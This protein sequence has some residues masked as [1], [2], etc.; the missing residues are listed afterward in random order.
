[1]QGEDKFVKDIIKTHKEFKILEKTPVF[2]SLPRQQKIDIKFGKLM[3]VY[4]KHKGLTQKQLAPKIGI[5][6]STVKLIEKGESTVQGKDKL[7]DLISREIGWSRLGIDKLIG[8]NSKP[9][10]ASQLGLEEA[11]EDFANA[12]LD[13][14]SYLEFFLAVFRIAQSFNVPFK[15]KTDRDIDKTLD[16]VLVMSAFD[17]LRKV[18][19]ATFFLDL[20]YQSNNKKSQKRN[21]ARQ[22]FNSQ[23]AKNFSKVDWKIILMRETDLTVLE[24]IYG[25]LLELYEEGRID[26]EI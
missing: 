13:A 7:I 1:M 25:V 17:N 15:K 18:K 3:R 12:L 11:K 26:W 16:E 21:V 22:F 2:A 20:I 4:R 5:S 24:E 23:M 9:K 14:E 10:T 6:F 8:T 19:Y